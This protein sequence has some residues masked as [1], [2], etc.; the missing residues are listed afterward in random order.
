MAY[1]K[2]GLVP[3]DQPAHLHCVSDQHLFIPF[4]EHMIT[5]LYHLLSSAITFANRLDPDQA[6]LNVVPDL[7]PF[8]LT[9]RWYY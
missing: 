8:C 6:R 2:A 5:T 1:H 7:D 3:V 9:L 4:V